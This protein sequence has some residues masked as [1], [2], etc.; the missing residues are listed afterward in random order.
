MQNPKNWLRVKGSAFRP[1]IATVE[2]DDAEVQAYIDYINSRLV[3]TEYDR[4]PT[5]LT[6]QN[7]ELV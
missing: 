4:P 5:F 7:N 2:I 3:L 1:T 6:Q